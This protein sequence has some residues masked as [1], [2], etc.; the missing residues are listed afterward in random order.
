MNVWWLASNIN[1]GGPSYADMKAGKFLGQGWSKI[2]D[3]SVF[4]NDVKTTKKFSN[5]NALKD[6]IEKEVDYFYAGNAK[7]EAGRILC[8][9]LK[10]QTD[11]LVIVCDGKTV[12]GIAKIPENSAYAYVPTQNYGHRLINITDWKDWNNAKAGFTPTVPGQ[13]VNG[14]QKV[15]NN[16]QSIIT[17]WSKL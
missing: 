7:N 10:L 6:I 14:I 17:A 1:S 3:L 9:L 15:R 12:K 8:N 5:E 2:R 11:D 13:G 16:K 4:Y